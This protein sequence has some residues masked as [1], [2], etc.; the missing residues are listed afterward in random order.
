MATL[1]LTS[2]Y[3]HMSSGSQSDPVRISSTAPPLHPNMG[4]SVSRKNKIATEV[5][6]NLWLQNGSPQTSDKHCILHC[7][8]LSSPPAVSM[9]SMTSESDYA[10]P[11]DAY[12]TDTE[13]SEPE[14]KLP[15]TCSAAS[16]NGKSVSQ[17]ARPW[18]YSQGDCLT[19]DTT[20]SLLWRL[21]ADMLS[22]GLSDAF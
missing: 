6:L 21:Q 9:S 19:C 4:T 3:R 10:I 7:Q 11:P 15:K 12:S 17:C 13:C 18:V 20:K 1:W 22:L 14:Q 8:L 16:D 5:M 2:C